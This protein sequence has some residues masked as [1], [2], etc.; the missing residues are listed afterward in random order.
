MEWYDYAAYVFMF[1]TGGVLIG[2]SISM[3]KFGYLMY[4]EARGEVFYQRRNELELLIKL[5][6]AKSVTAGGAIPLQT[7]GPPEPAAEPPKEAANAV[8]PA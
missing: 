2:L 1:G 3:L 7:G 5:E 8:P 4:V 6:Q